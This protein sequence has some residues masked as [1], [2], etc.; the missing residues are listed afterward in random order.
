[1]KSISRP[2]F[3]SGMICDQLP[4]GKPL[5]GR[6]LR[7]ITGDMWYW[8]RILMIAEEIRAVAAGKLVS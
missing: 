6:I 4:L 1:M 2:V 5:A 7:L 8:T 3:M